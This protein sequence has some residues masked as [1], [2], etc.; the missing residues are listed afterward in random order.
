MGFALSNYFPSHIN[1]ITP[2]ARKYLEDIW[3]MGVGD[4][5][6][7]RNATALE[8][9]NRKKEEESEPGVPYFQPDQYLNEQQIKGLFYSLG[10]KLKGK[11]NPH[12]KRMILQ[13]V[14]T[15]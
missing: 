12:R 11:G 9:E 7:H 15:R 8:V 14:A 4:V 5:G 3:K 2:L 1:K 13:E 6:D 10:Q